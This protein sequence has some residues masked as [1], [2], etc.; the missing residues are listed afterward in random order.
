MA[1]RRKGARRLGYRV[2]LV[3][4]IAAVAGGMLRSVERGSQARA[5]SER[6]TEIDRRTVEARARLTEA[7]RRVD[8]LSSRDRILHAAADLGL[9]PPSDADISF[10]RLRSADSDTV[11]VASARP[12]GG[13]GT[14]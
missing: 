13:G 6:L 7:M 14:R 12:S 2:A 9:H 1:A 10:L 4:G 11:R 3:A 5:A 8:S